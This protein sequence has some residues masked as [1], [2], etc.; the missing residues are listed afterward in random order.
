[1]QDNAIAGLLQPDNL[2]KIDP[3]DGNEKDRQ[4][5][6]LSAFLKHLHGKVKVGPIKAER[7]EFEDLEIELSEDG[8]AKEGRSLI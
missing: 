8:E 4:L 5:Y 3:F 6:R 2:Y 7:K 1:M